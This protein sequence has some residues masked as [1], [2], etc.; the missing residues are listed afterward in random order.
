MEAF[1]QITKNFYQEAQRL[2][3]KYAG[4]IDILI[5]FE[6]EWIRPSSLGLIREMQSGYHWDIF[7]GSVH[8]VHT[9]PI[10]FDRAHYENA[11]T[12]AGGSDE[13]LFGDYFDS[14]HEMLQALKPPIVGH[15]DLIR[16]LS[17]NPDK[18]MDQYSSV[19]PK[20]IRN[21]E[22]IKSYG[23]V[24]EINTSALRKGMKEPYPSI[25][26]CK[27]RHEIEVLTDY[28]RRLKK[29]E[30]VSCSQTTLMIPV[31]LPRTI[32]SF[33]LLLMPQESKES[34]FFFVFCPGIPVTPLMYQYQS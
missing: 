25:S 24:L 23:G 10:D 33:F 20:V 2:R 8:H 22:F 34:T 15:L 18:T 16:L 3:D 30:A 31:M 12:E 14:Q 21:L 32:K 5:G 19:W 1:Y 4:Q 26:I 13:K 27:V 11:R 6:S 17:D 29:W 7:V 28:V 9:I